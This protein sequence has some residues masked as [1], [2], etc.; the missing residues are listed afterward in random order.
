MHHSRIYEITRTKYLKAWTKMGTESVKEERAIM[1]Y[2]NTKDI[3][4]ACIS[5]AYRRAFISAIYR[6]FDG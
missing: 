4:A 2:R 6:S 1:K 5:K 3:A